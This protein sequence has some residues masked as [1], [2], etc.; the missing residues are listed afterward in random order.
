VLRAYC[1]II[2]CVGAVD[3]AVVL[4]GPDVVATR[5]RCLER[6]GGP[7]TK[8]HRSFRGGLAAL[9]VEFRDCMGAAASIRGLNDVG[10]TSLA[11]KPDPVFVLI[12]VKRVLLGNAVDLD[13]LC[14]SADIVG[15]VIISSW[16]ISGV[17]N[18]Q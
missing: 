2:L 13:G 7:R 18:P 16:G 4:K 6:D 12:L 15:F 10:G 3:T 11:L 8:V 14:L 1:E 9:T 5:F 17:L